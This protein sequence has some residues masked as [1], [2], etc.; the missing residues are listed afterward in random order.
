[1]SSAPGASSSLWRRSP[2]PM[3]HHRHR[4]RRRRLQNA[5][6]RRSPRRP[7]EASS[8]RLRHPVARLRRRK[9]STRLGIR[10]CRRTF[11]PNSR[12]EVASP[13]VRWS[14]TRPLF[15]STSWGPPIPPIVIEREMLLR[16]AV[17]GRR[18]RA[19][20][21]SDSALW[22]S[23]SRASAWQRALGM[24]K[25]ECVHRAGRRSRAAGG[26][27]QPGPVVCSFPSAWPVLHSPGWRR[28]TPAAMGATRGGPCWR[29]SCAAP[30]RSPPTSGWAC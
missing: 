2:R 24:F 18:A 21:G 15:C 28:R 13:P 30:R 4:H 19:T 27:H 29:A 9:Q 25:D 20:S 7:M 17:A 10:V 5:R 6:S 11:D 26:A 1:M 8:V 22:R 12:F 14:V 16:R 23:T 3:P